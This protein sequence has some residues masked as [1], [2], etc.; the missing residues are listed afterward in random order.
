MNILPADFL[1]DDST[2]SNKS[3]FSKQQYA[4]KMK[5]LSNSNKIVW[6][7]KFNWKLEQDE[8]EILSELKRQFADGNMIEL[9]KVCY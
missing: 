2:S 6:D 8:I 4:R 3:K 9:I 5:A 7:E 1:E